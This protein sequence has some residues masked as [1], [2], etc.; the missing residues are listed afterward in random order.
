VDVNRFAF[1][2][3]AP[4]DSAQP[5][6]THLMFHGRLSVDALAAAGVVGAL[7]RHAFSLLSLPLPSSSLLHS[8]LR[9]QQSNELSEPT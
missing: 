3:S 6:L 8:C 9:A 4:R 1:L 7:C 5:L 2:A